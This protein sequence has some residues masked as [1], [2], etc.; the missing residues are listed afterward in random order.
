MKTQDS[1]IIT[2]AAKIITINNMIYNH[3]VIFGI[4]IPTEHSKIKFQN[5]SKNKINSREPLSD[6]IIIRERIHLTHR[7]IKNIIVDLVYVRQKV[8]TQK[9]KII[10][11]NLKN[12]LIALKIKLNNLIEK[13]LKIK[14]I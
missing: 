2:K 12:L 14:L 1:L 8:I 6:N 13:L 9:L 5:L 10:V 11:E 3:R 7:T 4:W